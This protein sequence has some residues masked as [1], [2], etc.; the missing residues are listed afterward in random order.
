MNYGL[1]PGTGYRVPGSFEGSPYAKAS[2]GAVSF[3]L[4]Q[5]SKVQNSKFKVQISPVPCTMNPI[6][7]IICLTL[8]SK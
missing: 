3:E 5:I 1:V 6:Y 8:P 2:G 4:F 7:L